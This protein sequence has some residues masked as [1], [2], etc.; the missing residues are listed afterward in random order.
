MNFGGIIKNDTANGE[1]LRTSLFVSGCNIKCP[2]CHN[3]ELQDFNYGRE[4]TDE[5]LDK[6]LESVNDEYHAGISILGGEP[7]DPNN[8]P[9]VAKIV[10]KFREKYGW[11]KSIWVYTGYT[12]EYLLNDERVSVS[13]ILKNIDTLVDGPFIEKERDVSLPFRGSANQEIIHPN[14]DAASLYPLGE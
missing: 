6:L 11:S 12:Y 5:D 14:I 13:C 2:G 8:S 4:F 10:S 7:L 9:T 3:K 1:G